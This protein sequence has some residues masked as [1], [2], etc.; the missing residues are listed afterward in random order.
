MSLSS[1]RPSMRLL[2]SRLHQLHRLPRPAR[3]CIRSAS[4]YSNPSSRQA[5]ATPSQPA[6][7]ID[8]DADPD[9]PKVLDR[10]T[11]PFDQVRAERE[12]AQ[13]KSY[14]M[15]RMRFATIGLLLSVAGL[16]ATLYNIDLD[17][18]EQ[19]GKKNRLQLDAPPTSN[20]KFQGREVHIIGAGDGKRIVAEEGKGQGETELVQTG[21]SSVPYFPRRIYLPSSSSPAS[22]AAPNS[23]ANLG[24]VNN[25][26]EY[27]LLG[28]GIRTVS[29]LR[30]Q[31]YV[32]G[33]YVRTTDISTLQSR[34]IHNIN[35]SASTLVPS[36]K[37]TLK[38]RLLDPQSSAEIWESLLRE[39]GIKSAWR[40]VPTR[41]TDFA[42]LRDGWITGIKKGTDAAKQKAIANP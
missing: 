22:S 14:H 2:S 27:T 39:E 15:Q 30:I 20:E 21:T 4:R 10:P 25:E 32:L 13:T 16:A 8:P 40:V 26:E 29:F 36:E 42:H 24:N 12:Y 3:Q 6:S 33:L 35:S 5:S 31:V 38:Q 18:L 9:A 11:N 17:D 1:A 34:L 7:F 19:S 23:A 41:N 28:L 37:E